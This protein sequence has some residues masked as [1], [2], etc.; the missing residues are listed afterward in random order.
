MLD[1]GVTL[2]F[3]ARISMIGTLDNAY[4]DDGTGPLPWAAGGD[5]T[6]ITDSGKGMVG[7]R[8]GNGGMISFSMALP[9]DTTE[10]GP[11][12]GLVMNQLNGSS[13][14]GDIDTGD[15]GTPNFQALDDPTQFH[16]FWVVIK[17][18]QGD[19]THSVR[20]WMDGD[21]DNQSVFAV[22]AGNTTEGPFDTLLAL[23]ASSTGQTGAFD[24][25][26][27]SV[28]PGLFFPGGPLVPG[29]T[30]GD[31]D[32]TIEDFEPIRAN[33]LQNVLTR[34]EGDLD[35]NGVVNFDDFD[36]F[37]VE[38]LAGGGSLGDI[39]WGGVPEP[40]AVALLVLAAGF[41]ALGRG[42]RRS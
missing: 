31:G 41:A 14:S 18:I 21:E 25:D 8:Q 17:G 15:G 38:F 36:E 33:F 13:I 5:G 27:V 9:T 22:T 20:I 34:E 12:G 4:P 19:R 26:F 39:D 29:D 42:R 16:E 24:L 23:G 35:L 7:I 6:V 2:S 37:K 10:T 11:N 28:K 1:D 30:N 3:R 32:V 40:T